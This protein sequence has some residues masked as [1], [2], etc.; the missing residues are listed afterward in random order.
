MKL[1]LDILFGL[2]GM[3]A[4][5]W[6]QIET[7]RLTDWNTKLCFSLSI[8][9]EKVCMPTTFLVFLSWKHILS[10]FDICWVKYGLAGKK[11]YIGSRQKHLQI[12]LMITKDW[13]HW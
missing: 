8:D 5:D 1:H 4:I 12:A 6:P 3:A 7:V 2:D 10:N 11:F 9:Y 13:D